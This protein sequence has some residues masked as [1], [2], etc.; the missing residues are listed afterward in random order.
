MANKYCRKF[1]NKPDE[2]DN[3]NIEKIDNALEVRKHGL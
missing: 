2:I 1:V 3:M